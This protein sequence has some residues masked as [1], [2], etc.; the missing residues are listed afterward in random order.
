MSPRERRPIGRKRRRLQSRRMSFI[1]VARPCPNS[2]PS[3]PAPLNII[4][5][6]RA[7]GRRSCE[8]RPMYSVD[9]CALPLTDTAMR[10]STCACVAH[11]FPQ[12]DGG[13]QVA[14][15]LRAQPRACRRLARHGRS[16]AA[17]PLPTSSLDLLPPRVSPSF[18]FI[19][20]GT[21]VRGQNAN[22]PFPQRARQP[23]EP[24]FLKDVFW[25][26][27]PGPFGGVCDSRS[28]GF[29]FEPRLGC[30]DYLKRQW[31]CFFF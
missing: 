25:G 18:I 5:K 21:V 24:G 11:R 20:H 23:G 17:G 31:F 15:R 7:G 22:C 30:R 13:R 6:F 14:S 9:T 12:Q 8:C 16:V 26:R 3:S 28:Q 29:K 10:G 19:G 4:Q 27:L 2:L 1:S